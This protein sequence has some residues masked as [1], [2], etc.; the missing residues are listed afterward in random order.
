MGRIAD[1]ESEVTMRITYLDEDMRVSE[2]EDGT[3]L[4]YR[5]RVA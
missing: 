3:Q 2:L 4:V 5:R 1:G